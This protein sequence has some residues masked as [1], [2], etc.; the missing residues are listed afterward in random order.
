MA[1]L[2]QT[3]T[4]RHRPGLV[5]IGLDLTHMKPD[6]GQTWQNECGSDLV[7]TW[8]DLAHMTPD[9]G[10]MWKNES[11]SGLVLMWHNVARSGQVQQYG[12]RPCLAGSGPYAAIHMYMLPKLP[13]VDGCCQNWPDVQ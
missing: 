11:V 4:T 7:L 2:A 10:Q 6:V 9:V 13:G 1:D 3:S 5:L 12:R 8:P